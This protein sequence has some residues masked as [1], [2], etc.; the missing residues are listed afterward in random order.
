MAGIVEVL[1]FQWLSYYRRLFRPGNLAGYNL[2]FVGFL[3]W[4]FFSRL[5]HLL[6]EASNGLSAGRP[7]KLEFLLLGIVLI[8]LFPLIEDSQYCI[9]SHGLLHFPFS[10]KA[11]FVIRILSLLIAPTAWLIVIVSLS[12]FYPFVLAHNPI[13]SMIAMLLFI[14]MSACIG[15][16]LS[17]LIGIAEW[18]RKLFL[19]IISLCITFVGMFYYGVSGFSPRDVL[20]FSPIYLLVTTAISHNIAKAFA[21]VIVML[22]LTTITLYLAFWSFHQ[23]LFS[24]AQHLSQS[25]IAGRIIFPGRLGGLLNKDQKYFW[26]LLD[27]Y[28][29]LLVGAIFC[30][31]LFQ[32]NAPSWRALTVVLIIIFIS[33]TS[34]A[35]NNFGL[36]STAGLNR[37]IIFPLSGRSI[38]LSKN[39]AYLAV[40]AF[41]AG[42]VILLGFW[43][44]GLTAGTL[45]LIAAALLS[46]SHM[47]WGNLMSISRPFKMQFY[48]FSMGVSPLEDLC[49]TIFCSLPGVLIAL[50][51]DPGETRDFWKVVLAALFCISLYSASILWAGKQLEE[52][53]DKISNFL[54][55]EGNGA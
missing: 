7:E 4:M 42:L 23:S 34:I 28:L 48:R 46:L 37:Y 31:Y 38:I 54:S 51:V 43:R 36:D 9:R 5:P 13:I 1:R 30:L 8:W 22:G 41:Q 27:S 55:G 32:A 33:N 25:F 12:A 2:L 11:L 6:L 49:G 53:W 52:R 14:I 35:I 50:F 19:T 18:R 29:G 21:A 47:A 16:T 45:G 15:L 44:L 20:A 26:R 39:L 17:H 40:M 3:C 10:L 24:Q